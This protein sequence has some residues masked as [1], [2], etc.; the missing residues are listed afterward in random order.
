MENAHLELLRS[1]LSVGYSHNKVEHVREVT[2][3]Q[4]MAVCLI[5]QALPELIGRIKRVA[6]NSI[7]SASLQSSH[8]IVILYLLKDNL[9]IHSYFTRTHFTRYTLFVVYSFTTNTH[10][11]NRMSLGY[12]N[13]DL[14][15]FRKTRCI[16]SHPQIRGTRD[17]EPPG[18]RYCLTI[19]LFWK[20]W[21]CYTQYMNTQSYTFLEWNS[22]SSIQHMS[23][24][25]QLTNECLLTLFTEQYKWQI[26]AAQ[27]TD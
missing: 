11:L 3:I 1:L 10:S 13:R 16:I 22:L 2:Q 20:W 21:H 7:H 25:H 27:A 24:R 12:T 19:E 17:L 5:G 23:L 9:A 18:N 6:L 4:M 15:V 14:H 26:R 8:W